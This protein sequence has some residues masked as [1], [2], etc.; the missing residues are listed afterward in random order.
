MTDRPGHSGQAGRPGT[1][2]RGLLFGALSRADS[3]ALHALGQPVR[4]PARRTFFI[5][6]AE[7]S[8]MLIIQTGR[9]EISRVS[10]EGRRA[11]LAQLGPGAVVGEMTALDGQPRSTNATAAVEVT[12]RLLERARL[13]HFLESRPEAAIEVIGALCARLR[14]IDDV[15]LDRATPEAGPRLARCLERLF[16][17][18]GK[19]G[20]A[21]EIR[22]EAGL[23]QTDLGDMCGLTRETVNRHLR[24][25]ETEG[26]LR[27]DGAAFVLVDPEGLSAIAYPAG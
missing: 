16:T 18:W 2:D 5:E 4:Y 9:V 23:S 10:A 21:H 7:D 12:G 17:D 22:M 24:R 8:T 1:G 3:Q 6:G 27:R 25:W 14:R 13:L 19:P 20:A 26:I 15:V 11:I